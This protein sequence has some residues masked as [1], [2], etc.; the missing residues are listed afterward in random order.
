[1]FTPIASWRRLLTHEMRLLFSLADDKAGRSMAARIAMM[2]ITT[3]S[4]I[5]VKPTPSRRSTAPRAVLRVLVK[6]RRAG[7]DAV[8]TSGVLIR[9]KVSRFHSRMQVG[10]GEIGHKAVAL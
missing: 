1:M 8:I 4:S 5:K 3:R 7:P 6:P 2:A 10:I 9:V